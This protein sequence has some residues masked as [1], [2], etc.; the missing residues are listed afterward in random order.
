MSTRVGY[1]NTGYALHTRNKAQFIKDLELL[2]KKHRTPEP[3]KRV[4]LSLHTPG[5]RI[6]GVKV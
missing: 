2:V 1:T 4:K 3:Q 6:R 5:K